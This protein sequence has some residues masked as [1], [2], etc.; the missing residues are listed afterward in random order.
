MG[1]QYYKHEYNFY[2]GLHDQLL[3]IL[4]L[5]SYA[6]GAV[7]LCQVDDVSIARSILGTICKQTLMF[8]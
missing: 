7:Y 2:R 3:Q 8:S 5:F 6:F 4:V 1:N